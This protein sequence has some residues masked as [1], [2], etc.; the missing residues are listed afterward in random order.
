MRQHNRDWYCEQSYAIGGMG[1]RVAKPKRGVTRLRFARLRAIAR[2]ANLAIQCSSARF[3]AAF[4]IQG[5]FA[6]AIPTVP[7]FWRQPD[8]SGCL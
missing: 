8:V 1:I 3:P 2:R 5:D 4:L 7:A 6:E